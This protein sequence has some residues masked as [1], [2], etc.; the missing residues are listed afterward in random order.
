MN[1]PPIKK[2]GSFNHE[3]IQKLKLYLMETKKPN[4]TKSSKKNAEG[5]RG[6]S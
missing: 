3:N 6:K 2:K 1:K 4:D 5:Y